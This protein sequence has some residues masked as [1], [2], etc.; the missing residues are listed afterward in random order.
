MGEP[1]VIPLPALDAHGS[2]SRASLPDLMRAAE[3]VTIA[4]A[5]LRLIVQ[6][7][8]V[9]GGDATVAVDLVSL[10]TARLQGLERELLQAARALE[11]RL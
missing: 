6:R 4:A 8:R 11:G 7:I 10:A 5:Q 9:R 1:S 3:D 2:F